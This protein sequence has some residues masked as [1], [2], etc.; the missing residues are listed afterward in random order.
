MKNARSSL[1]IDRVLSHYRE[2]WRIR[3]FEEFAGRARERGDVVGAVHMSTGQEAVPVGVC[4]NLRPDDLI[5]STH[6][7]HGHTIA[8]GSDPTAMMCELYGREGG[9]CGG[10]GG[11]MH[12]ADV[13]KGILGANGVVGAGINIAVG[14]AH[15]ISIKNEA[16]VVACFFGDGAINRGPFLEGLN[17]SKVYDLPVLF[18][19]EDNQFSSTTRTRKVTAG[20]GVVARA[21][22]LGLNALAVDGNDVLAIDALIGELVPKIRAGYGPCLVHASTF[23]LMEHWVGDKRVYRTE[24]ELKRQWELEPIERCAQVLIEAGVEADEL[25]KIEGAAGEEMSKATQMAGSAAWPPLAAAFLDVQDAGGSTW[26][27]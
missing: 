2:M 11:S 18:V 13:S 10:K 15:A 14:A 20:P 12:I 3:K 6:R 8:K 1:D 21:Q 17:W 27:E 23:R 19:C 25:R 5:T 26:Q 9:V 4:A 24:A 16:R 7:G 22:A